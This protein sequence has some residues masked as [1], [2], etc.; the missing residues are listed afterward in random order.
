MTKHQLA[1]MIDH[2]LLRPDA[3]YADLEREAAVA[4]EY[5]TYSLCVKPCDVAKARRMLDGSDV[6]IITVV[7]FPLGCNVPRVKAVEAQAAIDDGAQELDMVIN[8]TALKSGDD[9]LVA[10]DIQAVTRAAA[11]LP[12]K[13]II[14]TCLLTDA[15]K[16]RACRLSVSAGAAFVKTS[17][18]FAPGGAT[19]ADIRLMRQ[20]VGEHIG[21]KAS[22]GIRTFAQ[23]MELIDAGASRIG[24][25]ATRA[26]VDAYHD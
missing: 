10:Q 22:G 7:G 6:K 8:L 13:V 1:S 21:V 5:G 11:A 18:G 3:T 14:E 19:P 25:S 23:A 17:T 9:A 2:T 16:I 15:E 26:I 20:T 12:V 24:C 4:L